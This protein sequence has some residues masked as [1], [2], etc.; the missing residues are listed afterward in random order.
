MGE[1]AVNRPADEVDLT[2]ADQVARVVV[3]HIAAAVR[4]FGED[5]WQRGDDDLGRR[6]L[7]ELRRRDG[8]DTDDPE[9]ADAVD[10]LLDD[11]DDDDAQA[12][13]RFKVKKA[14]RGSPDALAAVRELLATG[15]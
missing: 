9:L 12:A 14:L 15:Q 7:D 2:E 10:D 5:L 3:P 13:V 8:P 6:L 1:V 4:A 11:P